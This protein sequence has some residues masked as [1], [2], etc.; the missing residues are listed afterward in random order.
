MKPP[1]Y[2]AW[3]RP[4]SAVPSGGG[5]YT[6]ERLASAYTSSVRPALSGTRP[7]ICISKGG[8]S[9]VPLATHHLPW[10]RGPRSTAHAARHKAHRLRRQQKES[11]SYGHTTSNHP[12]HT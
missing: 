7:S 5:G 10:Q 11:R 9:G 12:P 1:K 6:R 2:L 3:P 4:A 8:T